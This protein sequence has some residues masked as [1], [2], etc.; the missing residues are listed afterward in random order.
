MKSY[1]AKP[2]DVQRKWY[3]VDAEGKTLTVK[4][5]ELYPEA[6]D[7]QSISLEG[8]NSLV[9]AVSFKVGENTFYAYVGKSY[10]YNNGVLE[11]YVILDSEGN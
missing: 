9:D 8:I 10:S 5:S 11:A 4:V 3:I 6:T 7:I 1:I 2:A